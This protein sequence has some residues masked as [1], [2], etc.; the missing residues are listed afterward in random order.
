MPCSHVSF[1]FLKVC[2]KVKCSTAS[3]LFMAYNWLHSS[4][5]L[6]ESLLLDMNT[7]IFIIAPYY[8]A[9]SL[10]WN[11][12]E[13]ILRWPFFRALMGVNEILSKSETT[14][15]SPYCLVEWCRRGSVIDFSV[16][17]SGPIR[18]TGSLRGEQ[19]W[20]RRWVGVGIRG[21]DTCRTP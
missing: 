10:D 2:L 9:L 11:L 4:Q 5:N 16:K 18:R 7:V 6:E 3:F 13:F 14:L 1:A 20:T 21:Q 17:E 12:K 15:T 19:M 8:S